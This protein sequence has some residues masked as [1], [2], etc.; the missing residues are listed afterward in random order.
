MTY[1][2]KYN[3]NIILACDKGQEVIVL[4]KGLGFKALQGAEIAMHLVEKIFIP[5]ETAY[6]NRLTKTLSSLAYEY[7]LLASKIVD[8]AKEILERGL[9]PS[10]LVALADHLSVTFSRI[11]NHYEIQSPLQWEIRHIY[12]LEFKAGLSALKIIYTE[13]GVE[14]PEAEAVCIALHFVNAELESQD[15]PTT[16]KIVKITGEI[17]K[18]IESSFNIDLDENAV[19]FMRFAN[20]IRNMI[21]EYIT[22]PEKTAHQKEDTDLYELVVLRDKKISDCCTKISFYL[23][24]KYGIE[25][26]KNDVSFIALHINKLL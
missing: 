21:V 6:I 4:G 24:N 15:M 8:S 1:V 2:K 26:H 17:T 7:V 14:L 18:I 12:P 13:R 22:Q 19:E 16:F 23:K 10:V 11:E 9:N 5:Q 20:H 25:L 3:N